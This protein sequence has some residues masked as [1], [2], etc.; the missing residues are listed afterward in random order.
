MENYILFAPVGGTDPIAN[1][2]DGA[3]LHICRVYKPKKIYLYMSRDVIDNHKKDNRYVYCIEKLYEMLGIDVEINIISRD[4]L[5][6]V[7]KFDIFYDDFE[8]IIDKIAKE[9]SDS[10]IILNISSGTPAMKSAL[11][12]IDILSKVSTISIQVSHPSHS[13]SKH[14]EN[15]DDYMPE[16]Q[17]DCNEDNK[18]D[19]ENRCC[20]YKGDILLD[21]FKKEIIIKHLRAY[22]YCAALLVAQEL[23]SEV[24][25]ELIPL[26]KTTIARIQLNRSN[27]DKE[28]KE[29]DYKIIPLGGKERNI[30]EYALW[31]QIKYKRNDYAD[32]VRGVTPLIVDLFEL[33]LQNACK[34]DLRKNYYSEKTRN[35]IKIDTLDEKKLQQT[36]E[37]KKIIEVL[38]G[39]F[40]GKNGTGYEFG[41]EIYSVTLYELIKEFSND[42][43]VIKN[44]DKIRNFEK[45]VRN[46]AAHEIVGIDD[47]WIKKHG[48]ENTE[49][50]F[51]S[52][53]YIVEKV[54]PA[55][56]EN[57]WNSYDEL[58][59]LIISKFK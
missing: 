12:V 38:N 41:R 20:V 2:H 58:N 10:T 37:G 17:W 53:K 19:F 3:I 16:L 42:N 29:L 51:N 8:S 15:R 40:N 35:G 14:I 7:Q 57:M 4:D 13:M 22:D 21:K 31:L 28:S 49:G 48:G 11:T 30:L 43:K 45:N 47:E 50:I 52:I 1:D 55:I 34:I 39:A 46:I 23:K 56:D 24:D 25:K 36:E 6:D 33:Y 32:F 59:E 26:I 5:V 44:C 27:F 18:E 54:C 9:N